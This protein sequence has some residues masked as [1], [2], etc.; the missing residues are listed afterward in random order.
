MA[1]SVYQILMRLE[2]DEDVR[3]RVNDLGQ[4]LSM[5]GAAM[6]AFSAK[7]AQMAAEYEENLARL[8]SVSSEA[9]GST[10]EFGQALFNLADKMDGAI[11]VNEAAKASY[12]I[13]S[14]GIKDQEAVLELLEQG[15]R[16]AIGGMS[17]LGTVTD[18][19]TSVMNSY[20]SQL[21]NVGTQADQV[22]HVL[23]LMV[24]TQNEGKIT[25]DQYAQQIGK[26]AG[27]ASN[28]GVSLSE[29][30]AAISTATA[31]GQQS[32][33]A[34]SGLR[35]MIS[36]IIKPTKQAKD[37]AA[38]LGIEFNAAAL[39]SKGL[40]GV[41]QDIINSG[42]DTSAV[43]SKLFG[44]VEALATAQ[45]LVA[46]NG[47]K[48]LQSLNAMGEAGNEVSKAYE[49]VY[50]TA[51]QKA[52]RAFNKLQNNLVQ[53]GQGALVAFEP[54]LDAI[55]NLLDAFNSLDPATKQMI[56]TTI[57]LTGAASS[58]AGGLA[59]M[60]T[61]F[62]TL[63]GAVTA[64]IPLVV[65]AGTALKAL[66][67]QTAAQSLG[68][69]T[70]KLGTATVATKAFIAAWAPVAGTLAAAGAAVYAL[71]RHINNMNTEIENLNERGD[72][73]QLDP[74]LNT[75]EKFIS[76]MEDT[77]EALPEDQFKQFM[78]VLQQTQNE[79]GKNT[80]AGRIL[81]TVMDTM[82]EKQQKYKQA[83][84]ESNQ[85]TAK[86]SENAKEAGR[87][88]EDYK[89]SV[90]STISA[91]E[92]Q[93]NIDTRRVDLGDGSESDKIT[94][95]LGIQKQS[96]EK[97]IQYLNDL[98]NQSQ[99]SAETRIEAERKVQEKKLELQEKTQ[100]AQQ[101]LQE[102]NNQRTLALQEQKVSAMKAQWEAEGKGFLETYQQRQQLARESF[103]VEKQI[104][105]KRINNAAKGSAER[106]KLEQQL[107]QRRQQYAQ[108]ANQL[109]EQYQR[110]QINR[111]REQTQIRNAQNQQQLAQ[112]QQQ[113]EQS[114]ATILQTYEQRRQIA[115]QSYQIEI[116]AIQQKLQV[117]EQGSAREAEL[118]QQLAEAKR[119]QI[120]RLGELE[121]QYYQAQAEQIQQ[122]IQAEQRR[123]ELSQQRSQIQ[124]QEFEVQNQSIQQQSSLLSDIQG[125]LT[126][127][128]TTL[129][130]RRELV[131][132]VEE[133]TGKSLRNN[134]GS[135]DVGRAQQQ[136][137][138]S[139]AQ[140]EQRKLQLKINQLKNDREQLRVANQIK[141]LDLR[142][143]LADI[144]SQLKQVEDAKKRQQLQQQKQSI[145]QKQEL[146]E[147][148]S[149]LQEKGI[150]QQI[151]STKLEKDLARI[152][153]NESNKNS[154]TLKEASDRMVQAAKESGNVQ[155]QELSNLLERGMISRDEYQQIMDRQKQAVQQSS[156]REKQAIDRNTQQT[157][158]VSRGVQ[159]SNQKL[160]DISRNTSPSNRSSSSSS[161]SRPSGPV[162]IQGFNRMSQATAHI[163]D[164]VHQI[165][166]ELVNSSNYLDNIVSNQRG[167]SESISSMSN[168][169]S[170]LSS[171]ISTVSN[172]IV[173]LRSEVANLLNN[174]S[175]Q[176]NNLPPRIG[177]N[178]DIPAPR[179]VQQRPSG[180]DKN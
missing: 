91:L 88:F 154:Q 58:L 14:A 129:H 42:G 4:K 140:L 26:V 121:N 165:N 18:A 54:V 31:K 103:Q 94:S 59:V 71:N 153:A 90:E 33:A 43:M 75:A 125:K 62:N 149:Q 22:Q 9:T 82:K 143:E 37:Q 137:Q 95:K 84:Q 23:N 57:A 108:Q 98:A 16:T 141:Q 127:Q 78:G 19:T 112:L 38:A 105:Q 171:G 35:G 148:K 81:Q 40:K 158:N 1:Q 106:A 102:L 113:W 135:L 180:K 65:Q 3:S 69:L 77:G 122:T 145:S 111:I 92:K 41:L 73:M 66:Q 146:T 123:L 79:V 124:A 177:N 86:S 55:N 56:G 136:I 174:I 67:A 170:N 63:S 17:D 20:S 10:E 7:T 21:Q 110:E 126:S 157:S 30:N 5:A 64:F 142:S 159:S 45:N 99:A 100:Q 115:Q 61:T 152:M 179:I 29:L 134:Q 80:N 156:E 36:N 160:S 144:Q 74:L 39:K 176:V 93:A 76:R 162:E 6:T 47:D 133:I 89:K 87:S 60:V 27:I 97:Q 13:L 130:T 118:Q 131:G 178:I 151:E 173:N 2:G 132:L 117:V 85:A 128:N 138:S 168:S 175:S 104:M 161:S 163:A 96:I 34:F 155:T 15:Q 53:F 49:D 172:N 50:D 32:E 169:T 52:Q 25:A 83:Q 11:Q 109:E 166:S 51:S 147:R 116:Q 120:Q 119:N 72:L 107:A 68:M 70:A 48:F 46:N 101:R 12:D 28:A 167:I 44:D 8:R 164:K 139:L 114:G 150:N 24:Q